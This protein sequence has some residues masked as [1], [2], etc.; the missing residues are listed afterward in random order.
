MSSLALL[1]AAKGSPSEMDLTGRAK[2]TTSEDGRRDLYLYNNGFAD[3]LAKKLNS[4]AVKDFKWNFYSF[5]INRY[6]L[7]LSY[8][9]LRLFITEFSNPISK[10]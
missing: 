7:Y 5:L 3:M 9:P 6:C 8:F 2:P 10:I 1:N 4:S